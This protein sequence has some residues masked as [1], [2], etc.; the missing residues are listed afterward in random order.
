[1]Y[2][3]CNLNCICVAVLWYIASPSLPWRSL[4]LALTF[5]TALPLLASIC[6][7]KLS[8]LFHIVYSSQCPPLPPAWAFAPHPHSSLGLALSAL[9]FTSRAA[10]YLVPATS[11]HVTSTA[12]VVHACSR[13]AAGIRDCQLIRFS[14]SLPSNTSFHAVATTPEAAPIFWPVSSMQLPSTLISAVCTLFASLFQHLHFLLAAFTS[15][16][17]LPYPASHSLA[18]FTRSPSAFII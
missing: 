10:L 16:D 17:Y 6:S 18:T 11:S 13:V 3:Y 4:G 7:S 1:M 2:T 12:Q 9:P 15:L 5:L 14:S 8:I